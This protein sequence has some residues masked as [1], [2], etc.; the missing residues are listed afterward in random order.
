VVLVGFPDIP[1]AN[2]RSATTSF[3]YDNYGHLG[4]NDPRP[5]S[6]LIPDLMNGIV[7]F[8]GT[9]YDISLMTW[10]H[11][12][13]LGVTI[14]FPRADSNNVHSAIHFSFDVDEG[15]AMGVK[16]GATALNRFGIAVA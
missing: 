14:T 12:Q 10:P 11:S 16:I 4:N 6:D 13:T 15:V 8:R 7:F 2:G 5:G 3:V 9:R 1:R